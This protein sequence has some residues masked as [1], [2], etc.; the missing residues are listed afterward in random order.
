MIRKLLRIVAWSFSVLVVLILALCVDIYFAGRPTH[1]RPQY[2]AMGSSFAAGPA[3]SVAADNSPWFCAQSRDNYAHQL[4]KLRGLSLVDVTCSGAMTKDILV[5]GLAMLPAQMNAVTD[6]TE[7]VTVTIGGNDIGYL[8]NLMAMGCDDSSP[9]YV[10]QFGACKIRSVEQM[11][12][13]LPKVH[14]QLVA[15]IDQVHQRAPKAQVV[16][17]NYQTVLPQSGTC[18]RLGLSAEQIAEMRGIADQLAAITA[19]AAREHG[20]LLMDA[21]QVTEGHD[22]CAEEPWINGMRPAKGL[23]GA[24]LHPTLAGMTALANG[25][26]SL[27]SE[28]PPAAN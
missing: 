3:V 17:L 26:N 28:K 1:G 11:Q 4:A 15:I 5:G 27:V 21:M 13:A 24:P 12:Q 2:V 6:E 10:R 18:E 9:W 23:L 7:L 22:A 25:L 14:D 16:L 20:A 19:A 8:G